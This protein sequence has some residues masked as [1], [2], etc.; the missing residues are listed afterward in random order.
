MKK[1]FL[2]VFTIIAHSCSKIHPIKPIE[3]KGNLL[4]TDRLEKL[5]KEYFNLFPE[6]PKENYKVI[7]FESSNSD[8][9][10]YYFH[11]FT[12]YKDLSFNFHIISQ[13]TASFGHYLV[14]ISK[15][16]DLV[17]KLLPSNSNI[18]SNSDLGE[19]NTFCSWR[20]CIYANEQVKIDGCVNF[21]STQW[22]RLPKPIKE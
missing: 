11:N 2:F 9:S 8:S 6:N 21:G 14:C 16:P 15:A 10:I 19:I 17:S 5:A 7:H 22:S 3:Q 1:M 18:G 20:V 12:D 4:L 13:D